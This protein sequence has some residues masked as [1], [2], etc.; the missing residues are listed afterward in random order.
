[1][2]LLL[3][4][5]MECESL[6]R[7]EALS[8]AEA[9]GGDARVLA[10]EPGV[11]VLETK[12]DPVKL[13]GRLGLCH[14]VD[15]W[16]S[17]C[18]EDEVDSCARDV[19]VPGP[20]RVRSTKVGDRK[21][22]LAGVSRRVG[23]IV[24]WSKGVDLHR[25]AS[26]IRIVFSDKVHIGRGVASIARSSFEKRKN[27]YMPFVYPAS[28]HPK[29]AR[30]LV[31]LV[32]TSSGAK[33]LDPFCGTGAILAEASMIGME[34][35]GTDFDERMIEGAGR[36]LAHV[37]AKAE[38]RLCDVGEIGRV[39]G[40]VD[41]VST[42]PPYGRSTTTDGEG[43]AGLYARSFSSFSDVL[44]RKGRVAMATPDMG[45]VEGLSDFKLVE[46]HALWVHRSLTRNF[47]VLEKR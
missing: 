19:D 6:A 3:E 17:S 47:C 33:V 13:A 21:V 31:N 24:G 30:A 12:A 29:Y 36:N 18:R 35:I 15:E 28:L 2:K 32:R 38:L 46:S 44:P 10:E 22:D 37:S 9:L 4:L 43:I 16:V 1:M 27:R 45:L 7:A 25:P 41:G 40:K 26:D 14:Y 34:A 23:A 5:S 20:I 42:D 8:A 39:V 11:L